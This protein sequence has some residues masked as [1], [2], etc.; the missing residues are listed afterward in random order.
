MPMSLRSPS[1]VTLNLAPVS[2]FGHGTVTN[3]TQCAFLPSH[4][5]FSLFTAWLGWPAGG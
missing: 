1:H 3:L 5:S 2:C 4:P